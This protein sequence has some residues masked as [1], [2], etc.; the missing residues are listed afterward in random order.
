EG[1]RAA[2][3]FQKKRFALA[4]NEA[5]FEGWSDGQLWNGWEKPR[6]EFAVCR[7]IL[8]WMGDERARFE[9]AADAFVTVADEEQERWSAEEITISDGSRMKVYPLGAGSWIWEEA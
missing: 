6:F 5:A 9:D 3:L 1:E 8:R 4:D 2:A 7:E